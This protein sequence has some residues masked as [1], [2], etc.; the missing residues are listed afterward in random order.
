MSWQ[1]S[2]DSLISSVKML[3][4]QEISETLRFLICCVV[5]GTIEMWFQY[6]RDTLN[7][8]RNF[9]IQFAF[10]GDNNDQIS[11]KLDQIIAKIAFNDW[12]ESW[13][14][15]IPTMKTYA[16]SKNEKVQIH[17][18]NILSYFLEDVNSSTKISLKRRHLLLNHFLENISMLLN[19][20]K[21]FLESKLVIQAYLKFSNAI[22]LI[23]N[24]NQE[25]AIQFSQFLLESF[26]SMNEYNDIAL[27]AIS[28]LLSPNNYLTH[29][30]PFLIIMIN[31]MEKNGAEI[32]FS[33]NAFIC[34]YLKNFIP[35]IDSY[36]INEENTS[37]LQKLFSTVL[38]SA[39]RVEFNESFWILWNSVL[40]NL[41]KSMI[42]NQHVS[43]PL[44]R[45]ISPL[46]PLIVSTFYD[47]LPCS[48]QLSRLI[49][50]LTSSS[51]D[52]LM[53][54]I[55]N[56]TIQFLFE[57]PPSISLCFA[58]GIIQRSIF[59]IKLEQLINTFP[60]IQ[61]IDLQTLSGM[62]FA[63]S[64]NT[65]MMKENPIIFDFFQKLTETFLYKCLDID[66]NTTVLLAL[67]HIASKSPE[68]ITKTQQF[69]DLIFE[70]A[71]PVKLERDNFSRIC[72]VLAK[73]ILTI[74]SNMKEAYI[75][76]LT[77]IA[78][79]PLQ[80]ND[81][82]SIIIGTQAAYSIVSISIFGSYYIS[83]Y[84]WKPLITAMNSTQKE[85]CFS[86]IVSVF[87]S[88][89][90]TAP[91]GYCKK[92]IT[93]FL[94][95][96]S[97][98][99]GHDTAIL[100][101]YNM[102]YQI[103]RDLENYRDQFALN[104]VK[105]IVD[106]PHQ[107]FFEF[108]TIAGLKNQEEEIVMNEALSSIRSPDKNIRKS[109][110]ILIKKLVLH[111]KDPQFLQ[112]WENKIIH[113]AF[114]ALFDKMDNKGL[115]HIIK[116]IYA[117]YKRHI[118]TNTLDSTI[119]SLIVEAICESIGDLNMSLQFA[120]SLRSVVNNKAE[121]IELIQDFLITYGRL[122]PFEIKIFDDSLM[123]KSLETSIISA[124]LIDD[125]S[126]IMNNNEDEYV[127]QYI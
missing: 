83:K 90:R 70:C 23:I 30:I 77:N 2:K 5:S 3:N 82:N 9:I 103:H 123:V 54:I 37:N 95:L 22:C 94:Q 32:T 80:S 45:I 76:R 49:T 48:T 58:V 51:F 97:K 26:G 63:I 106:S 68:I 73:V 44:N 93:N 105:R 1:N 67:N 6:D 61:N 113:A 13:Q 72:R 27:N 91:Y 17:V 118:Q 11:D 124:H 40:S 108:F 62:L 75:I 88:S 57:Q 52:L 116:L 78:S 29:L 66:C 25:M 81:L 122:N 125:S 7:D 53:K 69:I 14:D 114:H 112:V 111:R 35:M 56:E 60:N 43:T 84:L 19:S 8:I 117:I 100:D 121:F 34:K 36:C 4:S 115:I 110:A 15:F 86:D 21:D 31:Q 18:F 102:L 38:I 12:P 101:A 24:N 28:L 104:F 74:P 89:L 10:F 50:P 92:E 55:P 16:E 47:L 119:D 64:R 42:P 87:A 98:V 85:E 46:I 59:T 65:L 99:E 79:I 33:L 96:A 120:A 71:S 39:S 127:T 126:P 107:S 20:S 109:S 41:S